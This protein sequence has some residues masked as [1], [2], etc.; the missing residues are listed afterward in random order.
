MYGV[1]PLNFSISGLSLLA[2]GSLE[3]LNSELLRASPQAPLRPATGSTLT[4]APLRRADQ[5]FSTA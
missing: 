5:C 1:P 4:L 2:N 3:K